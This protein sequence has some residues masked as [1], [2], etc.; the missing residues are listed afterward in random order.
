MSVIATSSDY[1]KIH[2]WPDGE[3][4]EQYV[5]QSDNEGPIKTISWGRDGSWLVVVPNTG[6][7]EVISIKDNLK[8]LQ[9]I[10][11]IYHP[12]AAVF[13][14]GTKRNITIGTQS[15]QVLVY[16]IKLR[17]VKKRYPRATS[18]I[19]SLQYNSKDSHVAAA[20]INGDIL[21]YNHFTTNLS[22]SYRIPGADSVSSITFHRTKRNLLAAGSEEGI[23]ATWDINTNKVLCDFPAHQ[24]PVTGLTFS[25]IRSDLLVTSGLDRR[26]GFYDLLSHKCVIE[27]EVTSSTTALDFSSCGTYLGLGSQNGNVILYDTRNFNKPISAFV[28]HEGKK[29]RHLLFQKVVQ[30]DTKSSNSSIDLG[31]EE[32]VKIQ[33]LVQNS[34][35]NSLI[36]NDSNA[37]NEKDTSQM[38]LKRDNG[39]SFL[40]ALGLDN[41]K[42]TSELSNRHE[43]TSGYRL[44]EEVQKWMEGS[45]TMQINLPDI[46]KTPIKQK[47]STPKHDIEELSAIYESPIVEIGEANANVGFSL[48][49]LKHAIRDIVRE[50]FKTQLEAT[51]EEIRVEVLEATSHMRRQFLD[52]HMAI[53]KQF[54]GIESKIDKI[55]NVT[56][57]EFIC[58]DFLINKNNE[59][60]KEVE[61]LREQMVEK[62]HRK[63]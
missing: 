27:V 1:L 47:F 23:V 63:F 8:V 30:S 43:V 51:K 31:A 24:G 19:F 9:T 17:N 36:C 14:N 44:T 39:D 10:Q 22:S 12:T 18:T 15:G 11:D 13:Q 50:E 56:V 3:L 45:K 42:A 40:A 59:L 34:F 7:T 4:K 2:Q 58:D 32:P 37:E 60:L 16:D 57:R 54:V 53:V 61:T 62:V 25:P 33:D 20:C 26:F 48:D 38:H 21:V 28:A 55:N 29:I 6:A 35:G 52:L 5:P 41:S 46:S 49:E